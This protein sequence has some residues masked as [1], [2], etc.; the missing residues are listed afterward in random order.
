MKHK[1]RVLALAVTAFITALLSSVGALAATKTVTIDGYTSAADF[2]WEYGGIVLNK[3]KFPY[4]M[5]TVMMVVAIAAIVVGIL[6][7]LFRVRTLSVFLRLAFAG[8]GYF[9]GNQVYQILAQKITVLAKVPYG[10]IILGAAVAILFFFMKKFLVRVSLFSGV[11]IAA[12]TYLP[13]FVTPWL[14]ENLKNYAI[15]LIII[16]AIVVAYI[17]AFPLFRLF[18]ALISSAAA[19]LMTAFGAFYFLRSVF[20]TNMHLT[21]KQIDLAFLITAGVILL[22]TFVLYVIHAIR[23]RPGAK[24]RRKYKENMKARKR[25]YG[26]I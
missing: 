14:P 26:D 1:F 18:L 3:L 15:P 9:V 16:A 23:H 4:D 12:Y 2:I 10:A 21:A 25:V 5:K 22:L 20:E 24:A 11:V 7:F 6:F 13:R 19:G 8:A 17:V